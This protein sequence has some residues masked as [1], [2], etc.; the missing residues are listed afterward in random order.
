MLLA[1]DK[2][3]ARS[4][5]ADGHMRV[6][7]CLLTR[8]CVSEYDGSEV[9]D[10]ARL[11]WRP[12]RKYCLFRDPEALKAAVPGLEGKPLLLQHKPVTGRGGTGAEGRLQCRSR[13]RSSTPSL[14]RGRG[15]QTPTPLHAMD[16][17]A[18]DFFPARFLNRQ[19]SSPLKPTTGQI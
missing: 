13:R 12:G 4:K 14:D 6:E 17:R 11:G 3:S 5:D 19:N 18:F 10:A 1:L 8:A 7:H 9:P 2:S 16:C 15:N